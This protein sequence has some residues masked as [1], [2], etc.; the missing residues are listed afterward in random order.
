ML[1]ECI[2]SKT[3][4]FYFPSY[5]VTKYAFLPV[6]YICSKTILFLLFCTFPLTLKIW[7]QPVDCICS[8]TMLS[9]IE[10]L[11]ESK[12]TEFTV[13]LLT[14]FYAKNVKS[15]QSYLMQN[16]NTR[17]KI[18]KQNFQF[19]YTSKKLNIKRKDS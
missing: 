14:I 2:C 16:K 6:D 19:F 1:Y 5:H 9:L 13:N 7:H 10:L 17:H 8:K 15:C 4:L 3:V 11:A 18:L 12:L